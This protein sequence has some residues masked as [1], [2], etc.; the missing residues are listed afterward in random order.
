[1]QRKS[2]K[3]FMALVLAASMLSG[4]IFI[5]PVEAKA[6]IGG[7]NIAPDAV[8]SAEKENTPVKNVNDGKLATSNPA[9]SWNT[10][11][12]SGAAE[13]PTPVTLTW[14][15]PMKL[16]S[17]EVMWWADNPTP[18]SSNNVTFP[19]AA[20]LYYHDG[21][22]WVKIDQMVNEDGNAAAGVGVKYNNGTGINGANTYWNGV[23]FDEITTDKLQLRINRNGSGSNGIGISEWKVYGEVDNSILW[24][25]C[26]DGKS[27]IGLDQTAAFNGSYRPSALEGDVSYD[28]EVLEDEEKY[29]DTI[30]IMG[31][32]TGESVQVKAKNTGVGKLQLTVTHGED[33]KST[34]MDIRI[35]G[36]ESMEDYITSTA[37]GKAPI[38]PDRIA[39]N[40]LVFDTPTPDKYGR[41]G[42]NFAEEFNAKLLPVEWDMDSF[43]ESD[44]AT[45][46]KTFEVTGQ[47]VYADRSYP[48]KAVINVNEPMVVQPSN[49]AVTFEN[50]H[51]TDDF[52]LPKQKVNAVESLN[53]AIYRI[54]LP[55][56]GEPNFVNAIKRLNGESYS[57]FQGFVFQDTDIY[58]TLEAISY[59]LSVIESDTDPEMAAQKENLKEVAERWISYI[60]QIQYA[61]GYL[62]TYFALRANTSSGGGY[63][64]TA[65]HRWFDMSQHEMYTLGHFFEAAV[66]YTR[67]TESIGQPDYRLY[68]VA[69][70]AADHVNGLFGE[71][72][73]RDGEVP[74]HEEI[75][76]AL[77]KLAKLVE[78]NEG[79]GTGVK[80]DALA[81]HLIDGRGRNYDK[82][83]SGYNAGSY[84]QDHLPFV[85]QDN[86]VGH[87][88]RAAY[89]YS[90]ASDIAAMLPE[91]DSDRIAYLNVL[92]SINERVTHRNTFITGAVGIQGYSEGFGADY[93]LDPAKS[94]GETCAGIA[95]AMWN[96]RMNLVHEDAKYIDNVERVLYNNVLA[97][98]NLD[99]NKFYYDSLLDVKNGNARSDWFGCACCPPNL[100]RTIASISGYMYAVHSDDLFVNLY[101][102]S[103]G[104]VNVNGTN[105]GIRQ[106]TAY[107]WEGSVGITLTPETEKEFT[108]HVRIP[109]WVSEQENQDVRITVKSGEEETSIPAAVDKGYVQITRTW[110]A[111]DVIQLDL[112]MEVRLTEADENIAATVGKVAIE[113]GPIVYAMERA[114][115]NDLNGTADFDPHSFIIPKDAEFK[116]AYNANLLNGVVEITSDDVYQ[117]SAGTP[118]K[119]QAIPYYAWNNRGNNGVESPRQ[120]NSTKMVIWVNGAEAEKLQIITNPKDFVGSTEETAI[121]NV[122]AKGSNLSYQWEYCNADSSIWRTSSMSGNDTAEICVPIT[123]LRNGQKYRCV[124]TDGR[125]HTATSGIAVL[126]IGV[127]D[128][129]PEITCQPVSYSGVVGEVATFT[130]KARGDGLTFQWQYCNEGANIWRDSSM[131]GSKSDMLKVPV[132]AYRD[133]QKYRLVVTAGNGRIA[134]SD[135]AVVTVES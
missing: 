92:D 133:G 77:V 71:G 15:E 61:D 37:A 19:K 41:N 44:Y 103:E 79:E 84:S 100:M 27:V 32:T 59:T 112:P 123:N 119:L 109:G 31:D 24:S 8:A 82:R 135:V 18:T 73:S 42:Y 43:D 108:M 129:A 106:E 97:G 117:N 87:S 95:M 126:K 48:A 29:K 124:V 76:L 51:L 13:Y 107:P 86:V 89:L 90:G 65:T 16:S 66:A 10:W 93:A 130:G 134:I 120:N 52:W 9:T 25:A 30:E 88:V 60:E 80:Y 55:S 63:G 56:G 67:Y 74:G 45:A 7:S 102:G 34:S 118:A 28:W 35:D 2:G 72:G 68:V 53:A 57:G 105:V 116:A 104:S 46:G 3:R 26:I 91:N 58:K 47:V 127:A 121:F 70:R 20:D 54:G 50:I 17:M 22:D 98:T 113:R 128:G 36:P 81:K 62:N 132:A 39:V 125:K 40:G 21:K 64:N 75:E 114:G 111:G 5:A 38:L 14:D 49:S 6:G 12:G 131:P 78:E 69:K 94:Y 23:S 33:V 115:N 122:E 96:Q 4:S 101:I 83:A 99:G 11:D 85:E 1:M 110:K